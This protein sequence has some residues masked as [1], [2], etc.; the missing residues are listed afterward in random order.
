VVSSCAEDQREEDYL[1][2]LAGR[3]AVWEVVTKDQHEFFQEVV[4]RLL[5]VAGEVS[6]SGLPVEPPA[7]DDLVPVR[8]GLAGWLIARHAFGLWKR[9][10]PWVYW[11]RCLI[12]LVS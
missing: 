1:L 6:G 7:E 12:R 5:E 3:L 2:V 4:K 11:T 9:A 10:V 8:L